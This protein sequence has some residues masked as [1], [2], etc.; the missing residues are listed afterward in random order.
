M[1]GDEIRALQTDLR[2]VGC[3]PGEVDGIFGALTERAV[4]A[5]QRRYPNLSDSGIADLATLRMLSAGVSVRAEDTAAAREF[6]KRYGADGGVMGNPLP[7]L[8][9]RMRV[10]ALSGVVKRWARAIQPVDIEEEVNAWV[11][12]V[13]LQCEAAGIREELQNRGPYVD[14]IVRIGGGNPEKAPAWCAYF[15]CFCRRVA[16]WLWCEATGDDPDAFRFTRSGGAIRTLHKAWD[17]EEGFADYDFVPMIGAAYHRTRTGNPVSDADEAAQGKPR[18]GHT[19]IVV[20]DDGDG[21][22]ICVGGNSSGAGHSSSSRG[23][24]VALE[25]LSELDD[26]TQANAAWRRVVGYTFITVDE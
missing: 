22:W 2:R 5:Y 20:E 4:R 8:L 18:Q 26:D 14:P 11:A 9:A 19:G 6:C 15:V 3:D 1:R 12:W 13:A 25:V 17:R 7:G 10:D 23:G 16:V 21:R 24:R